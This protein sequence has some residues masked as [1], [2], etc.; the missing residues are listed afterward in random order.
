MALGTTCCSSRGHLN[1]SD[2]GSSN[3]AQHLPCRH[4]S[5]RQLRRGRTIDAGNRRQRCLGR[6]LHPF[7]WNWS[8]NAGGRPRQ[9]A[10]HGFDPDR[11]S[12]L[13]CAAMDL[14]R[15]RFHHRLSRSR[16]GAT[17]I[18][19]AFALFL[20]PTARRKNG[21]SSMSTPYMKPWAGLTISP[22]ASTQRL[23]TLSP[24]NP[25]DMRR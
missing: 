25:W 14:G 1:I 24:R 9:V 21:S 3:A 20:R 8:I 15:I 7:A 10:E 18:K 11:L 16:I 19:R 23:V 2:L 22:P 6:A 4:S 12:S 17:G 5:T 13:H